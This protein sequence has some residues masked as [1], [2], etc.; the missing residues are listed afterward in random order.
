MH[1][2]SRTSICSLEKNFLGSLT[3]AIGGGGENRRGRGSEGEGRGGEGRGEGGEG[4]GEGRE[5]EE[6]R[7]GPPI[8]EK[9]ATLLYIWSFCFAFSLYQWAKI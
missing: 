8:A 6:G 1:Y 3:L 5:R 7:A 4:K 9:S 2:N